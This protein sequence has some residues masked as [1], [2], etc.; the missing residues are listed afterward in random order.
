LFVIPRFCL[1]FRSA[2]EE[3][4]FALPLPLLLL[5]SCHPSAKREDLLFAFDLHCS[6]W[7]GS[8]HFDRSGEIRFSTAT[9]PSQRRAFGFAVA[10]VRFSQK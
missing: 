1:S 8:R 2:A 3:S 5:F 7:L 6:S 10:V 9:S 4:A